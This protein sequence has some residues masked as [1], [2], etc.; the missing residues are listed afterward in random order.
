MH[1]LVKKISDVFDELSATRGRMLKA[2]LCTAEGIILV[3]FLNN[4]LMGF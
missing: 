3:R 4:T 2:A 1:E